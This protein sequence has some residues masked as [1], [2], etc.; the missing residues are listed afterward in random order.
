ML[1]LFRSHEPANGGIMQDKNPTETT[2]LLHNVLSF[3]SVNLPWIML[4]IWLVY[5]LVP[6][7]LISL[8]VLHMTNRYEIRTIHQRRRWS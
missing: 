6:V 2:E 5:G 7:L 4:A 3:L 1:K 8:A